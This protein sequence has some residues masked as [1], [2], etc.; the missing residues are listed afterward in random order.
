MKDIEENGKI[1]RICCGCR[2]KLELSSDNFHRNKNKRNGF[3][4]RCKRCI[5]YKTKEWYTKNIN[6]EKKK[7]R[8]ES[9]KKSKEKRVSNGLCKQCTNKAIP[10]ISIIKTDGGNAKKVVNR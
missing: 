1:Y 10:G 5:K 9:A 6:D 4:Y 2:R 8:N 7:I 3:E